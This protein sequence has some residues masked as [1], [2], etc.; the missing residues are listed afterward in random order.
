V[1][2]K[3]N[4]CGGGLSLADQALH[5]IALR[6]HFIWLLLTN[7]AAALKFSIDQID[8]RLRRRSCFA[9]GVE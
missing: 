5:R 6:H 7:L 4:A 2:S 1:A 8:V 3:L 9:G